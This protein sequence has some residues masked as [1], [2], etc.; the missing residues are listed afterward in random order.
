MSIQW[1]SGNDQKIQGLDIL[2]VRSLDQ[3]I[4]RRWVAGIPPFL[5]VRGTCPYSHGLLAVT[6][7]L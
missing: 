3:N 4:E 1:N 6:T 7:N 2:E 5:T